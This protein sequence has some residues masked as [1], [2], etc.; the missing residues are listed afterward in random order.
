M[1]GGGGEGGGGEGGGKGGGGEGGGKDGNGGGDSSSI[2]MPPP[3]IPVGAMV[4]VC[5]QVVKSLVAHACSA[6]ASVSQM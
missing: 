3:P 4:A 2:V 6:S 5:K 1:H